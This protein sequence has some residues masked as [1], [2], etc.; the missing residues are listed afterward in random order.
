MP[1]S[2]IRRFIE[3]VGITVLHGWG[4]TEIAAVGTVGSLL[5]KHN[6]LELEQQ[7]NVHMKQGRQLWGVQLKIVD[8]HGNELPRYSHP[9]HHFHAT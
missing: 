1:Q 2:M 4:M 3:E 8:D 6:Q 5:P 9:T 7:L